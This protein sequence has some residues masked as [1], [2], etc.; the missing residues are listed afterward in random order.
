MTSIAEGKSNLRAG[1]IVWVDFRP[2]RGSE[3]DGVRPTLVLADWEFHRRDNKAIVCPITKNEKPWP[4]KV[5]IPRGA[6]VRGAVLVDQV[7]AVDRSAWG[8]KLAG[9]V[10]DATLMEVRVRLAALIGI[11]LAVLSPPFDAGPFAA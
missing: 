1:D 9:R 10:P 6:D 8:F 11:D 7:C 5:I 2:V 4:T 3:Q